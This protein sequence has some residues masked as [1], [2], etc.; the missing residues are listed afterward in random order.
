MFTVP[1]VG[2]LRTSGQQFSL[3]IDPNTV[4]RNY[5]SDEGL[6]TIEVRSTDTAKSTMATTMGTLK[7]VPH[8]MADGAAWIDPSGHE[9]HPKRNIRIGAEGAPTPPAAR[10][11]AVRMQPTPRAARSGADASGRSS[12]CASG[13]TSTTL[14]ANSTR[15]V[16]VGTMY[17]VSV[18]KARMVYTSSASTTMGGAFSAGG[19]SWSASGSKT[20]G[21][22]FSAPTGWT[23]SQRG[24]YANVVFGKYRYTATCS[25]ALLGYRWYP[26]YHTG[27]AGTYSS[28][29]PSWGTCATVSGAYTSWTRSRSDG[30]SYSLSTGVK[31]KSAIG[32]DLSVK[33][34]YSNSAKITYTQSRARKYCGNDGHAPAIAGKVMQKYV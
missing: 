32:L 24:A 18:Q 21:G 25:G 17:P 1:S 4:P 9:P 22:G 14:V 30:Y 13:I 7:L 20:V 29:R 23:N 31:F 34:A 3:D 12:E 27:G 2:A 26:R 33:R 11:A 5:I 19:G 8:S 6:V 15:K 16:I 10:L 28:S